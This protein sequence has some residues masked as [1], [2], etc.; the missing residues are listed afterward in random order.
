MISGKLL[1][2]WLF[3]VALVLL[4]GVTGG[5]AVVRDEATFKECISHCCSE[6]VGEQ[7]RAETLCVEL[8]RLWNPVALD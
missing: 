5:D 7:G 2:V 6:H 4:A 1:H 8:C 3:Q